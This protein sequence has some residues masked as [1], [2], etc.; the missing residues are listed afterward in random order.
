MQSPA[1]P[2]SFLCTLP[3]DGKGLA[4]HVTVSFGA[5]RHPAGVRFTSFVGDGRRSFAVQT[6]DCDLEGAI[7]QSFE[8]LCRIAV[9]QVVRD[10]LYDKACQGDYVLD[11]AASPWDGEL[12]PVGAGNTA[13]LPRRRTGP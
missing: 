12:R 11:L 8:V 1:T 2:S 4:Y 6:A 13:N 7:A 5:N 10:C 3:A 9:G